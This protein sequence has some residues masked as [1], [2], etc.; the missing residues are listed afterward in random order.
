MKGRRPGTPGIQKAADFIAGE[1]KKAGLQMFQGAKTYEQEFK[2]INAKFGG[3]T[4]NFNGNTLDPKTV[5]VFTNQPQLSVN[6]KSGYEFVSVSGLQTANAEFTKYI[7][8]GKNCIVLVDTSSARA[9][10]NL[11]RRKSAMFPMQNNVVFVLGQTKPSSFNIEATHK[12]EETKYMNVVGV[13]QGKSKKDEYVIFSGH[14]DHLGF[15]KA[16]NGDSLYNGAND[17]AAGTTSMIMLSK[18]FSAL[19]NNERTIVFAAFTA[20]E[21]GGFGATYFSRQFDPAKVV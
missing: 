19:K 6:E 16:V 5:V 2:M 8:S 3:L 20:E 13:I 15:G 1:F 10:N 18:Y 14:Y 7:Q 12:I 11:V 4:A 9:F 17:D 21:S